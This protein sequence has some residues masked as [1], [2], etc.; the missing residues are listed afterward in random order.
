M[1]KD[2]LMLTKEKSSAGFSI[3]VQI[4]IRNIPGSFARIVQIIAGTEASLAEV[5]L[6]SSGF[7]YNIREVTIACKSEP[8][9]HD[10]VKILKNLDEAILLS[11]QDDT[12]EMH[13][14]GKLNVSAKAPLN[15]TDELS[16]AY[17]PGVARVCTHIHRDPESAYSYTI[18]GKCV[19]VVT[20]GSAVLGLGNI[21]PQA[22]MPVMEGKAMLFKQFGDIDAFPICLDTQDTE[23]IIAAVKCISPTFGGINL[24]DISA[25]RCFEIEERLQKELEI[26]IFH[27]DQ[28]GTAVLGFSGLV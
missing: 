13:R 19:A 1:I 7:D 17:T 9:S 25:P 10:I 23:E 26:P 15:T 5:K 18:K 14:G 16:R 3:T 11:W 12:F 2:S 27:D 4:K 8:H 22:A 28:H 24:E 6:I 20:D 21:G